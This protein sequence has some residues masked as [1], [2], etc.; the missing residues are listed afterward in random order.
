MARGNGY[1]NS[2]CN[3]VLVRQVTPLHAYCPAD[4]TYWCTRQEPIILLS[5]TMQIV[6]ADAAVKLTVV[7]CPLDAVHIDRT[8]AQQRLGSLLLCLPL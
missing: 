4:E 5:L 6:V 7:L 8:S 3:D 2:T 1:G